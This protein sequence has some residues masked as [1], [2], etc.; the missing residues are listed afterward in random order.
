MRPE[1][2][3]GVKPARKHEVDYAMEKKNQP[4]SHG[5]W[6][7]KKIIF[8]PGAFLDSALDI[9]AYEREEESWTL[10]FRQGSGS[11]PTHTH[12]LQSLLGRGPP[13]TRACSGTRCRGHSL[14][15]KRPIFHR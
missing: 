14:P 13:P 12:T 8:N 15:S 6:Y 10:M 5:L 11:L 3:N 2:L 7:K 9:T 1:N 4:K